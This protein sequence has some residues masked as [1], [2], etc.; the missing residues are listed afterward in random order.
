MFFIRSRNRFFTEC[1]LISGGS[2][3]RLPGSALRT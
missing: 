2:A 3:R 1:M